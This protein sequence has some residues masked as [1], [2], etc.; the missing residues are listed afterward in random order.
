MNENFNPI[1]QILWENPQ[2]YEETRPL[3]SSSKTK[4]K[5]K[6][7]EIFQSNSFAQIVTVTPQV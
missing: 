4:N 5:G 6:N 3:A 2:V 7:P 1:Y